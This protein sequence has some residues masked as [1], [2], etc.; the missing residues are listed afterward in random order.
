[1]GDMGDGVIFHKHYN[2][3]GGNKSE[4]RGKEEKE[5]ASRTHA[6]GRG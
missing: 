5:E 2:N 4:K 3:N 6:E 1:M